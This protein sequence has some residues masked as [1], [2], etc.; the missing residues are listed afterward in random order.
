VPTASPPKVAAT[1]P[2]AATPLASAAAAT[3]RA[4]AAAATPPASAAAATTPGRLE[5]SLALGAA[6]RLLGVHPD[7]LRRWSDEGRVR[8]YL[9]P[10]GHRRFDRGSLERLRRSGLHEQASLGGIGLTQNRVLARYRRSYREPIAGRPDPRKVAGPA[11][12]E[13]FRDDGRRLIGALIHFLDATDDEARARARQDASTLVRSHA[14]RLGE[15]RATLVDAAALFVAAREPFLAEVGRVARQRTFDPQQLT[16][17][18]EEATALLD[19][20]LLEF[21][22]AYR[23]VNEERS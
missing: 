1:T 13:A 23:T 9:T 11:E 10:G 7:T 5:G 17:L 2:A 15:R 14:S 18:Y 3:P 21:I 16:R 12:A 19:R 22:E 4:S 8:T 6:S 20:L